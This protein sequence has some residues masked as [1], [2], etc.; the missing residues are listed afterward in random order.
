M[1]ILEIMLCCLEIMNNILLNAFFVKVKIIFSLNVTKKKKKK[2]KKIG[3]FF[4]RS[5]CKF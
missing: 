2:K 3:F 1:Y 4:S 5:Y